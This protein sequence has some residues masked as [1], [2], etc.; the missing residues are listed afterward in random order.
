M[1]SSKKE[2]PTLP[3]DSD[4]PKAFD[5]KVWIQAL[6][7]RTLPLATA[8]IVMGSLLAWKDGPFSWIVFLLA[9]LTAIALQILSNLANDYGDAQHGVDHAQRLGPQRVTQSGLVT[10]RSMRR[11]IAFFVIL[12]A[13]LGS[14]LMWVAMS[15][16]RLLTLLLFG[17]LGLLA[18]AAAILYT[19]G[20]RPYGYIGL[21]DLSVFF[22]FGV[23][24]VVG[25]Y[26]LQ[27]Q[28]LSAWIFLPAS[29]IGLLSAGVLNLNN[30]RDSESD[31]ACGK[32]TLAVRLGLKRARIYHAGLI[33]LA[34][35]CG[36]IDAARHPESSAIRYL[37]LG[38]VPVFTLH[39]WSVFQIADLRRFNPELKRL[40]LAT[41]LFA[42]LYGTG[43]AVS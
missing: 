20:K 5:V 1:P 16:S 25:S 27:T 8:S 19:V 14:A 12:S 38:L 26:Y 21:G 28:A 11:M 32:H 42:I 30:M 13:L 37:F 10:Q 34:I 29:A 31:A 3:S 41:F 23:V 40:A 4:S 15:K 33:L 24:G 36:L 18:I 39:L 22:F 7:L 35:G 17:L 43:M 9:M 6:R 2:N